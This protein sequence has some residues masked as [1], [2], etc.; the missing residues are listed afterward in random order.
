MRML[1]GPLGRRPV[2]RRVA[3]VRRERSQNCHQRSC[4]EI[5]YRTNQ[6][7]RA[8]FQVLYSKSLRKP[9]KMD[10]RSM[11]AS[12]LIVTSTSCKTWGSFLTSLLLLD[13]MFIDCV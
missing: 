3:L 5:L 12:P 11:I 9:V 4:W 7:E 10:F 13:L 8:T 2:P 6:G 1:R